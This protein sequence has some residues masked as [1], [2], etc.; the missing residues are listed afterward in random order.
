VKRE[1]R[2]PRQGAAT[3]LLVVVGVLGAFAA[4]PS[5]QA[6]STRS[7]S[8]ILNPSPGTRYAG[9]DRTRIRATGVSCATA[10]R[11]ARGAHRKALGITP[12][13]S[14]IRHLT[15]DDWR[16]TGDLR[17]AHDTYVAKRGDKRVRWV[18]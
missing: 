7:C 15:W 6:S 4:T 2:A 13:L 9:E 1:P 5:A 10:H 16:V 14:G 18:F 12:P 11:V 3:T 8:P 17:G